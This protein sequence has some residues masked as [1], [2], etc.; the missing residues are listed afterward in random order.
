[1]LFVLCKNEQSDIE[2]ETVKSLFDKEYDRQFTVL[3]ET[4]VLRSLL[5]YEV[6]EIAHI[7]SPA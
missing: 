1:M 5:L 6:R 4:E 3:S 2:E 7:E